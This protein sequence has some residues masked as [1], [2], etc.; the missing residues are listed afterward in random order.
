MTASAAL[1]DGIHDAHALV[2]AGDPL[3]I[4]GA[5]GYMAFDVSALGA[6]FHAF[7]EAPAAGVVV[8]AYTVGQL[9]GLIPIPG[10][11]GG[12]D[13]AL[14]AAF[15]IYGISAPDAAA[16]VLTYRTVQLGVPAIVGTIAFVR[17][18]RTLAGASDPAALCAAMAAG[19]LR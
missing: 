4:G 15:V 11:V 16:A 3:V 1:A 12:V 7:G 10:G 19:A 9:G 2:R 13:G 17:L 5:I 18:Q 8:L 14:I 6:A